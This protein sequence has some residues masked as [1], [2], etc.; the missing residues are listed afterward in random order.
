MDIYAHITKK[1]K[2][3]TVE[4]FDAYLKKLN[5]DIKMTKFDRNLTEHLCNPLKLFENQKVPKP[6]I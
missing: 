2:A 3:S 5:C 1:S 6:L 4:K